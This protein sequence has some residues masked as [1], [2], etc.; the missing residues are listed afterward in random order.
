MH[1]ILIAL[2][3]SFLILNNCSLFITDN[4]AE[5]TIGAF[6]N[7]DN[8]EYY[9]YGNVEYP[10]IA[11]NAADSSTLNWYINEEL[12]SDSSNNTIYFNK[13]IPGTYEIKL[14]T[15]YF[16][17]TY[18]DIKTVIIPDGAVFYSKSYLV[19]NI[20]GSL[21]ITA[22]G[23]LD[24]LAL[25]TEADLF[26]S[27]DGGVVWN[28]ISKTNEFSDYF[29]SDIELFSIDDKVYFFVGTPNHLYL[30]DDNSCLSFSE[31]SF[32]FEY[33]L[34]QISNIDYFNGYLFVICDGTSCYYSNDFG[35]SFNEI[36]DNEDNS[37]KGNTSH[38]TVIA[39]YNE[40][41]L[42]NYWESFNYIYLKS[43]TGFAN[44]QDVTETMDINLS[45]YK[46]ISSTENT[47]FLKNIE[48]DG[49]LPEYRISTNLSDFIQFDCDFYLS[50]YE[51]NNNFYEDGDN[52]FFISGIDGYHIGSSWDNL[53][54]ISPATDFEEYFFIYNE[55]IQTISANDNYV[56]FVDGDN[57]IYTFKR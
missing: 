54:Y 33:S 4:P 46:I 19:E 31:V 20:S 15:Q 57:I 39:R 56:F 24:V 12:V 3:L 48:I 55:N 42:I 11:N 30:N 53:K 36:K 22:D 17:K 41:T 21:N 37:I 38:G 7:T 25:S 14:S 18:E 16:G 28:N 27:T 23:A 35:N 49:D 44:W 32:P 34:Q 9:L 29:I 1:K 51:K 45:S 43:S 47:I 50:T 10:L 26:M 6:N 2:F 5:I 13:N 40:T 52:S 8:D